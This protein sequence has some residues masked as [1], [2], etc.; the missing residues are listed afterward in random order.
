M[1]PRAAKLA[2]SLRLADRYLQAGAD[3]S[4]GIGKSVIVVYQG[5][6]NL[7]VKEFGHAVS[8][9]LSKRRHENG[10]HDVA[11][12]ARQVRDLR[13]SGS[14]SPESRKKQA[15]E[16]LGHAKEWAANA[17]TELHFL[18]SEL[19]HAQLAPK[20]PEAQTVKFDGKTLTWKAFLT[21]AVKRIQDLEDRYKA[22]AKDPKDLVAEGEKLAEEVGDL[23]EAF[24]DLDAKAL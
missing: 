14:G 13:G 16:I 9:E 20:T 5:D 2:A 6:P 18:V 23:A 22:L 8:E 17:A 10:V 11:V 4:R 24:W 3:S 15:D 1:H 12:A 21:A 7:S 19:P